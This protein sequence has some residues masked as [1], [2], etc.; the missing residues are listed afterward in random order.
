MGLVYQVSIAMD[1]DTLNIEGQPVR[2]TAG[3]NVSAEIKTGKRTV[4][5]YLLSPLKTTVDESM[6]QR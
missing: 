3:M 4:L 5:E 6:K 2:L 1:N